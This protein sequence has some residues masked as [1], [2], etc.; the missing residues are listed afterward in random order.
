MLT[1][2]TLTPYPSVDV[3]G[4]VDEEGRGG[5]LGLPTCVSVCLSACV[6]VCLSV[7]RAVGTCARLCVLI[8]RCWYGNLSVVVSS[9]AA[10]PL[11]GPGCPAQPSRPPAC[12]ARLGPAGRLVAMAPAHCDVSPLLRA[13]V[14]L[15]ALLC[16]SVS[17]C[18]SVCACSSWPA[19]DLAAA[20]AAAA[21]RDGASP[22]LPSQAC[23]SRS[24]V[25]TLFQRSVCT[26]H[27]RATTRRLATVY[28]ILVDTRR[29]A[30]YIPTSHVIP[31]HSLLP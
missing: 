7:R 4:L 28:T 8:T 16:R 20:A 26:Q 30:D 31:A 5:V 25:V 17:C 2:P 21:G 10:G 13:S 29:H 1:H 15:S 19:I 22:S 23:C 9:S 12:P 11:P 3:A 24:S 27:D 18:V 6:C 14:R